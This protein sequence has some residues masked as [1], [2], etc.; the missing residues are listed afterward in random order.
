MGVP[1]WRVRKL[2]IGKAVTQHNII[3]VKHPSAKNVMLIQGNANNVT[4]IFVLLLS[5]LTGKKPV[6]LRFQ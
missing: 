6:V 3:N 1:A 2:N 5:F 4:L